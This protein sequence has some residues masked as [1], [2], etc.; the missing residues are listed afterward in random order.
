MQDVDGSGAMSQGDSGEH[1]SRTR[2]TD[3]HPTVPRDPSPP[4]IELR[5][6][7]KTFVLESGEE[8]TAVRDASLTVARG[9][10]VCVVGPSGHGKSTLLNLIA[11]F[12][13]PSSGAIFVNG[14]PVEGPGPDRGVVFQRDTLFLWRRV[15]ANISFGLEARGVPKQ[16]R[17]AT[18]ERYLKTV[19]LEDFAGAWPRQLSGGMR[20]RVAIAAVFANEPDVFLMDEPFV[21]L[22][23]LRRAQLHRVLLDLW[24]EGG[25]R[26][27]F[28]ITHDVDEALALG[29]RILVVKEGR[30]VESVRVDLPRPRSTYMITGEEASAIR[31]SV[32]LHFGDLEIA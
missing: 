27:V 17:K 18:V 6:V 8:L 15:A 13:E 28:M 3:G 29:D 10:F 22:D 7:T 32:V 12:I 30:I 1:A 9:E 23:Y 19:G 4:A 25:H 2:S 21:G 26:A 14:A 24:A 31:R 5:S 11:G 20:R 16:E